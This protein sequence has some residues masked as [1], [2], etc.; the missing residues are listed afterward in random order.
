M[1]ARVTWL[2]V[3]HIPHG[4][5]RVFAV[6]Q[7]ESLRHIVKLSPMPYELVYG[8]LTLAGDAG[9]EDPSLWWGLSVVDSLISEG[10]LLGPENPE[11]ADDG[12]IHV[13]PRVPSKADLLPL[14]TYRTILQEGSWSVQN[15]KEDTQSG[16]N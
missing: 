9:V 15:R 16:G 13:R 6:F 11:T 12:F 7:G 1:I 10:I 14:P 2:P 3:G 8:V 4:Y 5:R